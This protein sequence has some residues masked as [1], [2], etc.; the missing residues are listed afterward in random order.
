[1]A[2][3]FKVSFR[4]RVLVGELGFVRSLLGL[5]RL[6]LFASARFIILASVGF[7]L[8]VVQAGYLVF[9]FW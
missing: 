6:A 7:G 3:L 1:M 2:L 8:G 9:R 4:A 5:G